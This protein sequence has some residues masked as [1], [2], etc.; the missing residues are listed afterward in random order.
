MSAELEQVA[1][2]IISNAGIAKSEAF[3]ALHLAR[4]NDFHS[5]KEKLLQADSAINESHR[6]HLKL[7]SG[8][9]TCNTFQAQLLIT[10]AMDT[11]MTC[12]SE[13]DLIKEMIGILEDKQEVIA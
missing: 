10:H 5:V 9:I 2:E 12:M 13:I 8:Q 3:D 6:I 4:K 7:L 11:L 1:L